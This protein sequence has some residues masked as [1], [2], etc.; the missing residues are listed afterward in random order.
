M[1]KSGGG[2]WDVPAA[3][4]ATVQTEYRACFVE[5]VDSGEKKQGPNQ[6]NFENHEDAYRWADRRTTRKFTPWKVV[7]SSVE[8]TVPLGR[9]Q[10]RNHAQ[11]LTAASQQ[12]SA[13]FFLYNYRIGRRRTR[14]NWFSSATVTDPA[15]GTVTNLSKSNF[16]VS[17]QPYGPA[18]ITVNL[19][20]TGLTPTA[21]NPLSLSLNYQHSP[22]YNGWGG[23]NLHLVI[24][25]RAMNTS[26][27]A[28]A[29]VAMAGTSIHE[30]GHALGL[31]RG[32]PWE[33]TDASHSSHCGVKACVMWWQGYT[34]RPSAFHLND[35][36]STAV[37]PN[38]H[39]YVRG[40]DM[41]RG[42]MQV[43]RFPRS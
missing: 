18:R 21:A 33:T 20:G 10:A 14:R 40:R 17:T 13:N 8:Y 38:C 23:A 27:G 30:P 12:L 36:A 25:T 3:S 34:G 29:P 19:A 16:T 2:V 15:T 26:Y 43:W 22:G 6:E 7:Y 42:N 28:N 39:T 31:V 5:L 41:S 11:N 35:D 1:K 37:D 32:L 4:L 24:C 9:R